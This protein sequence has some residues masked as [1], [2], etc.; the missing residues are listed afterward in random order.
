MEV[1]GGGSS[2]VYAASRGAFW[3][4]FLGCEHCNANDINWLSVVWQSRNEQ[5]CLLELLFGFFN[6]ALDFGGIWG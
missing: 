4:G 5:I 1:P 2:A 6:G 3:I